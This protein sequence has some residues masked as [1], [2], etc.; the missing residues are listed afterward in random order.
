MVQKVKRL[1]MT[2][3]SII[4][5]ISLLLPVT[6]ASA[7]PGNSNRPD[8]DKPVPAQN[9]RIVKK[10]T[11]KSGSPI[12]LP[13]RYIPGRTRGA[14]TGILGAAVE[15]EKYA[16]VIGISDYPGVSNDLYFCDDDALE[17]EN[18][19]ENVY[20]F[21]SGNVELLLDSDATRSNIL[22]AIEAIPASAGEVVFS[23]SGHGGNGVALDGDSE[24][25]DE[26]ILAHDGI[27]ELVPIW[28][29]ELKAAFSGLTMP[30]I[31]LFD[32][33]MSG[34]MTDL[35]GSGRV[36]CMAASERGLSYEYVTLQNGQF[37]YYLAERGISKGYADSYD[38]D[39][40]G[41]LAK[42]WSPGEPD[43]VVIE[44]AFDYA[45]KR[46]RRQSPVISDS[47]P[48]DLLP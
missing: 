1:L 16:V 11:E 12:E 42:R 33:C 31:F 19:L 10:V 3:F 18:I 40:D 35:E 46:C 30:V 22:T 20:G 17:V 37:T 36:V 6:I 38:H 28:D 9:I 25:V 8:K 26:F 48:D 4:L 23:F 34:G 7:S 32:S 45:N 5:A 41:V 21:P 47:F 29:G 15:G 2:V 44:E 24:L 39:N 27:A 13:G 14:A 43:D